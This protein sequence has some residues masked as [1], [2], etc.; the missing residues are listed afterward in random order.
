MVADNLGPRRPRL[1]RTTLTGAQGVVAACATLAAAAVA[2][3]F[4]IVF[5]ATMAFMVVMAGAVLAVWALAFRLTRRPAVSVAKGP[6]TLE[7]RKVGHAW[8]TY[9]WDQGRR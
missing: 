8:I 6:V 1:G 3:L 7:A 4:A 5:A 9:G 2:A